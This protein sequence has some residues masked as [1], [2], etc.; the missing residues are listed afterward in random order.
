VF[1]DNSSDDLPRDFKFHDMGALGAVTYMAPNGTLPSEDL[2]IDANH[3][4]A[5]RMGHLRLFYWG[6]ARYRDIFNKPHM[7]QFCFEISVQGDPYQVP[8]GPSEKA[9]IVFVFRLCRKYN[10]VDEDCE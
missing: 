9:T 3:L 8:T 6:W 1:V 10:C 7:T 5:V 2:W 4:D